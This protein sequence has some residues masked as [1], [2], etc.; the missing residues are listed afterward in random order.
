VA[1]IKPEYLLEPRD[2]H[3]WKQMQKQLKLE[4][5]KQGEETQA[6]NMEEEEELEEDVFEAVSK[7][8]WTDILL[9]LLKVGIVVMS[10]KSGRGP[11]S[12]Y[13]SSRWV[14]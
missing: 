5:T 14:L 7:R 12:C 11:T 13:S 9:Q 8:A 2:Y 4:L 6:K 3:L 1:S 10:G